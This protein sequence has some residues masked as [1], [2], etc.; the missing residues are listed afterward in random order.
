MWIASFSCLLLF[1][2]A[3]AECIKDGNKN[4]LTDDNINAIFDMYVGR[5]DV[6]YKSRLANNKDILANDCNLSVSS[7]VEQKDTREVID[8][9]EVNAKLETLIT[10]GNELNAIIDTIIK[11][12][13]E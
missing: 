1:I 12:I 9:T 13:G 10:E 8:I 11:E 5:S 2:D 4:K 7:Y 3:S 6:D